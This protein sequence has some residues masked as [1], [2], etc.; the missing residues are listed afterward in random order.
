MRTQSNLELTCGC[1]THG[2]YQ[3]SGL[4]KTSRF[5]VDL[6]YLPHPP[7][8]GQVSPNTTHR[9]ECLIRVLDLY[10]Q[11]VSVVSK[12]RL[13]L[14]L[15]I[16]AGSIAS[17]KALK[18]SYA[19]AFAFRFIRWKCMK[20]D[21]EYSV[22]FAL[23]GI[24]V[25]GFTALDLPVWV[26]R[27]DPKRFAELRL[28]TPEELQTHLL[29]ENHDKEYLLLARTWEDNW[30][31]LSLKICDRCHKKRLSGCDRQ[32]PCS[33]CNFGHKESECIY[34]RGWDEVRT[35]VDPGSCVKTLVLAGLNSTT[36][37]NA[38]DDKDPK[39]LG[40]LLLSFS[41]SCSNIWCYTHR[42]RLDISSLLW[43]NVDCIGKIRGL[44]SG[45]DSQEKTYISSD[46]VLGK[47]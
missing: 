16:N 1:N 4:N 6:V 35:K 7:K 17:C 30:K 23:Y 26:P 3:R 44:T 38:D 28:P 2:D 43:E 41:P 36:K 42:S 45:C 40:K 14:T 9:E 20:R 34:T 8:Q 37:G 11:K 46:L 10:S 19:L 25:M 18:K 31:L 39:N 29:T 24:L 32:C 47:H 22:R 15:E 13:A 27:P 33:N 21:A 12:Q 5:S